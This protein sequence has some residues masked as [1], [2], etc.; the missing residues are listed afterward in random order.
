MKKLKESQAAK[1][2]QRLV[3]NPMLSPQTKEGVDEIIAC[4]MRH[5]KDQEHA[6]RTMTVFLDTCK[7][8]RNV[9]AEIADAAKG[10][11]MAGEAP[12]GCPRCTLDPHSETGEPRY[13]SHVINAIIGDYE[14]ATRC[15]CVRG[16]W[17]ASRDLQRAKDARDSQETRG[18]RPTSTAMQGGE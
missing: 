3:A 1:E 18:G 14:V 9:T 15:S 17:L 4:L 16:R 7:D 10:T 11:A 2:A 6:K 13:T 12:P 5:C 8:P